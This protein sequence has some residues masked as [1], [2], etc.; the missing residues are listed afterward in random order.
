MTRSE[1]SRRFGEWI[2]GGLTLLSL[3]IAVECLPL[4][5]KLSLNPDYANEVLPWRVQAHERKLALD[6]LRHL[7]TLLAETPVEENWMDSEHLGWVHRIYVE[8]ELQRE[9]RSFEETYSLKSTLP[10]SF[11]WY[12]LQGLFPS[13][14]SP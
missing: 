7:D 13:P 3:L 11:L 2:G 10:P 12:S 6:R 8:G 14:D 9:R 5:W 1:R 4:S